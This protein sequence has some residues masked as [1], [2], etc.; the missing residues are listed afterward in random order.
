MRGTCSIDHTKLESL[1]CSRTFAY[2]QQH[3]SPSSGPDSMKAST[4]I[5]FGSSSPAVLRQQRCVRVAAVASPPPPRGR[6]A[7]QACQQQPQEQQQGQ[8]LAASRRSVLALPAS[9]AAAAA[10]AALPAR[11]AAALVI[12]PAGFRYHEDKLDGYSFFYPEDWQPVTVS[13]WVLLWKADTPAIACAG[14]VDACQLA[15]VAAAHPP[16]PRPAAPQTSGNDVFYRNPF[17]VEENLFVNVSSPSSSKYA[18]VGDLGSPSGAAARIQQQVGWAADGQGGTWML[19]PPR[20]TLPRVTL[21]VLASNS[22][23]SRPSIR[24][25]SG[26]AGAGTPAPWAQLRAQRSC[27]LRLEHC[28][29]TCSHATRALPFHLP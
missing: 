21:P 7:V 8:Q 15:V 5:A 10:L 20:A 29:S 23:S 2:P 12:P 22:R 1:L 27:L 3:P 9:L 18:S 17:N 25:A 19:D 28:C 14:A 13:S 11:P 16:L 24:A 26:Q 6:T 4:V